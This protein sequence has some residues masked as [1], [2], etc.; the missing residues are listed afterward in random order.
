VF[1]DN[2]KR[3][4]DDAAGT[5]FDGLGEADGELETEALGEALALAMMAFATTFVRGK[6]G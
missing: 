4:G 5:L 1:V 6:F 2:G 3:S